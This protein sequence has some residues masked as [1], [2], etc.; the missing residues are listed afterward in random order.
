MNSNYDEFIINYGNFDD[1]IFLN[2]VKDSEYF[3]YHLD[4]C[5]FEETDSVE[6]KNNYNE[7]DYKE[8]TIES[9]ITF[10]FF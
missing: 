6:N 7:V 4:N 2:C 8:E 3:S 5:C 10:Y 1:R 9:R